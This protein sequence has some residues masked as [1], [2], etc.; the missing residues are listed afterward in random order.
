MIHNIILQNVI[1]KRKVLLD[2]F[3]SGLEILGFRD[4]VQSHSELFHELFVKSK[5]VNPEQVLGILDYPVD[6]NPAETLV[7]G[8][9]EEYVRSASPE[10]IGSFPT[11]ITG[12]PVLPQF[13]FGK[14]T[15]DF[16]NSPTSVYA[17]TCLRTLTFPSCFTNEKVFFNAVDAIIY[18]KKCSC[19]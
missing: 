5:S 10:K 4:A 14:I 3:A 16:D 12:A 7:R 11:F 8:Y 9:F 15:I 19:I 13:G 1:L 17:P 6:L 18:G 2:Q